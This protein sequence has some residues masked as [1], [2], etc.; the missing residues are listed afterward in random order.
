MKLVKELFR[1]RKFKLILVGLVGLVVSLGMAV[2]AVEKAGGGKLIR[3]VEDGIWF[4]VTT[5]TSV[6]YGD[7]YP[8]TLG[9][10]VIGMILEL[11]GVLTFGLVVAMVSMTLRQRQSQFYWHRLFKRLDEIEQRLKRVEKQGEFRIKDG[12]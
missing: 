5:A 6:G 1:Q 12:K 3:S 11:V 2:V 10:R 7:V 4:A 8:M 9:G